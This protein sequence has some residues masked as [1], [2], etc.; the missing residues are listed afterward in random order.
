MFITCGEDDE[1]RRQDRKNERWIPMAN[2]LTAANQHDS[3]S[4]K[5]HERSQKTTESR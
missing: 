5:K 3:R 1:R 4:W 2:K